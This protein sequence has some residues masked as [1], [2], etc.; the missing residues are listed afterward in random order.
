MS[1]RSIWIL[2]G[3]L[4]VAVVGCKKE[5]ASSEPGATEKP[6]ETGPVTLTGAGATF[7][8]PLYSKWTSEYNKQHPSVRINYQSIGSGGGIRQILARTVDFGASDDAMRPNE[9]AKAQAKLLHIPMTL[10]AVVVAYNVPEIKTRLQLTSDLVTDIFLGKI[11]KWNDPRLV[12]ENSGQTLPNQ[13][14]GVVYRSDGSGTT[15]VFTDYLGS[16]SAEWKEKVGVG[17]SIHWPTGLGAKGNEGVSGQLKTTPGSVGY[18]ELAYALQ[19]KLP[20][21]KIKNQAGQYVEPTIKSITAAVQGVEL[22]ET[23]HA[24]IVNGPGAD[25]YPI[26]AFTYILVYEDMKDQRKAKALAEF[27]WW[28][29]HDGQ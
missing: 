6:K 3:L 27:L 23:L 17:K 10:G 12:K 29:V 7:P 28:A 2:L 21:A 9:V 1:K 8:Y 16:V 15:A 14:I 11:K 24:S 13:D 25:A 4:L 18:I 26:A 19:N 5:T 22:P 20:L